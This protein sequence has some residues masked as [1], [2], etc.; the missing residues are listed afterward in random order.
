VDQAAAPLPRDPSFTLKQEIDPMHASTECS[1]RRPLPALRA[2]LLTAAC[3][4][5]LL[6][7]CAKKTE[8]TPQEAAAPAN[9]AQAGGSKRPIFVKIGFP[10]ED[11]GSFVI[12]VGDPE[13]IQLVR[14]ALQNPDQ[15]HYLVAEVGPAK[16]RFNPGW[17]FRLMPKTLEISST[18]PEGCGAASPQEVEKHAKELCTFLPNCRWCPADAKLLGEIPRPL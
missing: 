11:R 8:E 5:V 18:K 13:K 17:S 6:G 1:F 10:T 15:P 9:G 14:A 3:T 7:G 2:V 16:A 4:L 12:R